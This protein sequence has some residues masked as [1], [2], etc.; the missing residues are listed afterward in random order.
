M[1]ALALHAGVGLAAGLLL[2]VAYFGGLLATARRMTNSGSPLVMVVSL[3]LRLALA[4]IVLAVLARWS[5]L[6]LAG[7]VLGLL[8]VRI[9]ATSGPQLDRLFPA[10]SPGRSPAG[11]G[12]G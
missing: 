5:P 9:L 12:H 11:G 7:G 4:A 2:G 1:T 10:T 3:V 6:A 8:A